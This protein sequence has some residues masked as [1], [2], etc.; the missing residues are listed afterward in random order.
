MGPDRSE[1]VDALATGPVSVAE[2][3]ERF[4]VGPE[5]V[6]DRL[7]DLRAAG[8][9][10]A[11]TEDGISL[12]PGRSAP[13]PAATSPETPFDVE[14]HASLPS[15]N[16]LA[17]QRAEEGAVDLAV[18][19]DVQTGGRGRRDRAWV[20]P[21]GGAYVSLVLRPDWPPRRLPLVTLAAAVAVAR[22]VRSAGVD[23]RIKW[24]NDVLVRADGDERKLAGV[25][26]E[27]S[28]DGSGIR[29]VVV[30]IGANVA[31]DPAELP[32]T[33][34][35]LADLVGPVDVTWFVR[36][37][38]ETF[39][40]LR[41]DPETIVP[42]WRSAAATLGRRVEVETSAGAVAG[43]AVDIDETGALVVET[44]AGRRR[45]VAGECER[46]TVT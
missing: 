41:A 22:T 3:A 28:I 14:H 40:E 17:R 44:E 35:S 23:P 25:L 36:R 45:V 11:A 37:V 24:P 10:I 1:L 38:L 15:T 32:A 5:T 21:A 30:G 6:R 4:D 42:A 43:T 9:P 20:S 26:T 12:R 33:A 29:W 18:L 13:R 46:L 7:A 19:A 16:A 31:T 34:A 2:L 27:S 8:V 39:D